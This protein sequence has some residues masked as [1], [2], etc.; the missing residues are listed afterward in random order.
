MTEL[1]DQLSQTLNKKVQ[2]IDFF[3][4]G[5]IGDICK[6]QTSKENYITP[7]SELSTLGVC[8]TL[9]QLV[10]RAA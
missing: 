3:S 7:L 10:Y 9:C 4:K 5:Q 1:I 6:V 8:S 2:S